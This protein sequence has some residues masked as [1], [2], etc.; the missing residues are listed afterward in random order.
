[1]KKWHSPDLMA[2]VML[3]VGTGVMVTMFAHA[4]DEFPPPP[5][6]SGCNGFTDPIL[7]QIH[8]GADKS[9]R[10]KAKLFTLQHYHYLGGNK[11]DSG[12]GLGYVRQGSGLDMA[13]TLDTP[14][15]ELSRKM[16]GMRAGLRFERDTVEKS[17]TAISIGFSHRW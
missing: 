7:P 1:M 12:T 17:D 3:F 5:C 10:P 4:G 9:S 11:P 8:A 13:L 16:G 6:P 15:L 14:G 2:V